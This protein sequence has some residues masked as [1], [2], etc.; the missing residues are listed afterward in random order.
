[1]VLLI[2][3]SSLG[4]GEENNPVLDLAELLQAALILLNKRP[5]VKTSLGHLGKKYHSGTLA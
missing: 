1:M 4:S 2:S 5:W 3:S